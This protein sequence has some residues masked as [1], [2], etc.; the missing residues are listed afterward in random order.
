MKFENKKN[1]NVEL[2]EDFKKLYNSPNEEL[3]LFEKTGHINITDKTKPKPTINKIE[4]KTEH[5]KDEKKENNQK[6][7]E[8]KR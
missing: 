1:L 4:N 6:K 5:K 7:R 2:F 8:K 3:E